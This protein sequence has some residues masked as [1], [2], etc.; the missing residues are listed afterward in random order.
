MSYKIIGDS[1]IDLPKALWGDKRFAFVPLT[2]EIGDYRVVDDEQFDQK[3]F[4]ARVKASRDC[5]RTACPSPEAFLKAYEAAEAD[6]IYVITLS[7]HLSGTYQSALIGLHSF[8]EEHPDS[9]K[10][11]HVFDSKSASAGELNLA[12]QI[13]KYKEA[14]MDLTR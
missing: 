11:I 4:I 13:V 9:G 14:G 6:E 7:S 2:L 5:P 1:C 8:E 12:F 3:D 10:R